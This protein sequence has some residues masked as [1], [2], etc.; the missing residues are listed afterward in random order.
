MMRGGATALFF[1]LLFA[2]A[3]GSLISSGTLESCVRDGEGSEP[4]L[5]CSE[6]LVVTLSVD[7]GQG[8]ATEALE[9]TLRCINRL[10]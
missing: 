4:D 8:L 3:D 6:K 2:F 1:L 5:D 10:D 7:Q 9:T